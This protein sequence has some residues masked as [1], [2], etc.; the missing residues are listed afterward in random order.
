MRV[1]AVLQ[2]YILSSIAFTSCCIRPLL[3]AGGRQF[4]GLSRDLRQ[5]S[6]LSTMFSDS[7]PALEASPA[8]TDNDTAAD[9][10]PGKPGWVVELNRNLAKHKKDP[11]SKY[12]QLAT[13]T[14]DGDVSCRAVVYRGFQEQVSGP[15][16]LA[17][18]YYL[19]TITDRRSNKVNDI[20]SNP[21]AE[22]CWYFP[23]TREQLR[24]K[25]TLRLITADEQDA[26]WSRARSIQWKQLSDNARAQFYW[27]SP[28]LHRDMND[29]STGTTNDELARAVDDEQQHSSSDK[30]QQSGDDQVCIHS[31]YVIE[32]CDSVLTLLKQDISSFLTCSY[33][34]MRLHDLTSLIERTLLTSLVSYAVCMLFRTGTSNA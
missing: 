16:D 17:A 4:A 26:Q 33:I 32:P 10:S 30:P 7:N 6:M 11:T 34:C 18:F 9:A 20:T 3:P 1:L 24:I 5:T 25:G 8:T 29:D 15:N 19:K 23:N 27:P 22:I 31:C 28:G 14:A 13:A 2:L 21:R 12:M